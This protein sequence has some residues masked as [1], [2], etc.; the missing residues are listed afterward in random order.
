MERRMR[1]LTQKVYDS[2]EANEVGSGRWSSGVDDESDQAFS[3]IDG[4]ES[5]DLSDEWRTWAYGRPRA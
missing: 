1:T 5:P 3:D 2:N 4:S